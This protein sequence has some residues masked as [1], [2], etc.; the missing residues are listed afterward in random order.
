M[1][2]N[3]Q[4]L[5]VESVSFT[6]FGLNW[7][8]TFS[9]NIVSQKDFTVISKSLTLL[10]Y[11]SVNHLF[12]FTSWLLNV[13]KRSGYN[14]YIY[15][16]SRYGKYQVV[17]VLIYI[18][19]EKNSTLYTKYITL[20]DVFFLCVWWLVTQHRY[21]NL[22]HLTEPREYEFKEMTVQ[23]HSLVIINIWLINTFPLFWACSCLPQM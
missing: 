14:I 4:R 22:W 9:I 2:P 20:P 1:R 5:W 16:C 23:R 12:P 17:T 6:K 21:G 10:H 18:L 19:A 11:K 8:V 7:V 3:D 15:I 13:L